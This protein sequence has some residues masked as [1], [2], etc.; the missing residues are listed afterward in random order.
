MLLSDN[1]EN[2]RHRCTGGER[3]EKEGKS[4]GRVSEQVGGKGR[5]S[6]RGSGREVGMGRGEG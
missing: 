4:E 6:G 2:F 3:Q 1:L 5:V